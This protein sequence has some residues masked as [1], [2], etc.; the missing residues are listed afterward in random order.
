MGHLNAIK[1]ELTPLENLSASARLAGE[2]LS[3]DESLDALEAVGLLGREDLAC[4][5]LSRGRNGASRSPG[6]C[7]KKRAL[8]VLTSPL[9]H[10]TWRL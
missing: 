4:K 7:T 1:E 5:Y 9:S 10:S 6:W 2:T 3:E 8:W